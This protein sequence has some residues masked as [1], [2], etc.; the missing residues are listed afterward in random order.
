MLL[1]KQQDTVRLREQCLALFKVVSCIFA[2]VRNSEHWSQTTFE[3][4]QITDKPK[5]GEIAKDVR[6]SQVFSNNLISVTSSFCDK[7]R[8]TSV[9]EINAALL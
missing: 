4:H 7:A 3:L 6:L 8:K 1:C 9:E 5:S 2:F